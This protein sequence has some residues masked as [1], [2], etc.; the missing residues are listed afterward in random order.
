MITA[1]EIERFA[2]RPAFAPYRL[3][4][5]PGEIIEIVRAGRAVLTRKHASVGDLEEDRMRHISWDD[6]ERI[7]KLEAKRAG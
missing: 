7:E 2:R 3:V 5:K 4:P 6:V 1:E